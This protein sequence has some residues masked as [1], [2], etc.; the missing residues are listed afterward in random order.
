VIEAVALGPDG[1]VYSVTR[2][3]GASHVVVHTAIEARPLY[4]TA[5]TLR[6]LWVS[7][8]SAI[9]AAGKKHHTNRGGTWHAVTT[10]ASPIYAL[11]G[12]DDDDVFAG[13]ADG[14]VVRWRGGAWARI[15]KLGGTIF[16]VHGTGAT[17]VH[18]CGDA[19]H[20]HFD[21]TAVT[22]RELPP[23]AHCLQAVCCAAGET[24]LCAT[25]AL[26]RGGAR[27]AGFDDGELYAIGVGAAGLFVQASARVLRLDGDHFVVAHEGTALMVRNSD[28]ATCMTGNGARVVAGGARSVLVNDG[29]GFVEWPGLELEVPPPKRAAK[30]KLAARKRVTRS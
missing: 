25:S 19:V 14:E 30:P 8:A 28:Y 1:G 6:G 22:S 3:R 10:G 20:A 12:A 23:G 4:E 18:V 9:H 17:D 29:D 16:G 13:S 24:W 21:G 5:D 15:A 7:A 2:H 11:W 26:Y 27:V